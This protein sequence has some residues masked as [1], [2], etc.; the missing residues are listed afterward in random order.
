MR[1]IFFVLLLAN[2]LLFLLQWVTLGEGEAEA[3]AGKAGAEL[4][5]VPSLSLLPKLPESGE[6]RES[7]APAP[8]REPEASLASDPSG[9]ADLGENP[10]CTLVGPYADRPS[11]E[12][13]VQRLQA[14]D[15]DAQVR[16]LEV[17]D[18]EGYWVYLEP[19]LSHRAALR[20]LHELQA[21]QVDSYIIPRGDLENGISFGMFSRKALAE[22]RRD[23]M[24]DQG[25]EAR[26]R[27]IERT[28][29]E[30]WVSLPPGD[31]R[32]LGEGL[33][34]DLL[35]QAP[36]LERRQNFCPGVASE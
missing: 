36:E 25:Y 28:H 10:L 8:E 34:E 2:L 16:D 31:A 26:I 30:I 24:S 14:L 3:G 19:E 13:A 35:E 6:P 22:A 20:R 21:K 29:R 1:A 33:W 18:G 17:P 15:L 7:S 5:G 32:K 4:E 11:A 23:E 9:S 27:E 12:T